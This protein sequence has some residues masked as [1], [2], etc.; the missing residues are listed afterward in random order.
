MAVFISTYHVKPYLN[1]VQLFVQGSPCRFAV[2]LLL[3]SDEAAW[4]RRTIDCAAGCGLRPAGRR[5]VCRFACGETGGLLP[6]LDG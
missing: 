4:R 3:R 1:P 2:I 5:P 6:Q